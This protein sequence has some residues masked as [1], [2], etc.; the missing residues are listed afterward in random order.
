MGIACGLTGMIRIIYNRSKSE[1]RG[2][3]PA[4]RDSV[5]T[6]CFGGFSSGF[7]DKLGTIS[8]G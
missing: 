8:G 5:K 6:S 1:A 2:I 3:D 4:K 7:G